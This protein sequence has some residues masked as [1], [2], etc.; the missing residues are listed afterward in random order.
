MQRVS[1]HLHFVDPVTCQTA[2]LSVDKYY[3][4]GEFRALLSAS[5]LVEFM[6]LGWE[7][8]LAPNKTSAPQRKSKRQRSVRSVPRP[9]IRQ[10][11]TD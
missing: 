3:K 7:P 11:M 1:N 2:E 6:V 10:G 5:R 4:F 8:A 9:C